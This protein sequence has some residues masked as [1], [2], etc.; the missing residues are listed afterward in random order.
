[1]IAAPGGRDRAPSFDGRP[2]RGVAR[3]PARTKIPRVRILVGTSGFSYP[4]WKGTF[5]P[6]DLGAPRMLAWYAGRLAAVE[7]NNTFYRMPQ[8]RTLAHWRGEV[9]AGFV[10]AMKAPQ[11][12]THLKRLHDVE[13]AVAAFFR[14]G[15]ELG[16][17]LGP[18]L[19]QL[20]PQMKR[21]VGRL[22]EFLAGLPRGVRAAF[23]FR[24]VSWFV[25]DVFTALADHRAALVVNQ[26]EELE[27]PLAPTAPFGYL[28]LRRRAYAP[29]ELHAWA[30]RIAAQP[31]SEAFVFFK[32]EDE[33]RGPQYALALA[34]IVAPAAREAAPLA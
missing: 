23:E 4:A 25:E 13:D 17:A 10:F 34:S 22:R 3:A 7:V 18:A 11:R 16:P 29:E 33:A 26:S 12:I 30:E 15:A 9:P 6:P 28:R 21:D 2:G 5:Y 1:M 24:D 32:H 19:F 20:P 27:P 31:W 14:A 8:A